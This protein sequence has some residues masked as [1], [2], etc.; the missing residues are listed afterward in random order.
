MEERWLFEAISETYVPLIR[1][2]ENLHRDGIKF[3]MAM[4]FT[5]PLMSM[6]GDDLLQK[7]YIRH[8]TR[9][10]ELL[11][12]EKEK[13]KENLALTGLIEYYY[14]RYSDDL[15]IFRD[16]YNCNII[17]AYKK[18]QELG[19]L[20]IMT[21]CATHGFL[22]HMI[23]NKE[24]VRAQ[25]NVAC[26]SY[27][28][29]LGK[30]PKGIWLAECAYVR[31]E[32]EFLKEQNLNYFI[33][34]THGVKF[35]DPPP[36]YGNFAPI[37]SPKGIFAFPRDPE[38]SQQVW[39]A[40]VGY[41]GAPDYREFYRDL[42][43]EEEFDYIKP[44]INPDGA[45][46]MTGIKYYRITG[47]TDEK[48]YYDVEKAKKQAKIHAVDF[49]NKRIKQIKNLSKVMDAKTRP[50]VVS[51]YDAELYGHWW[52]EGPWFL[53]ELFRETSKQYEFEFIL[54]LEYLSKTSEIQVSQMA[55]CTWG[56]KGYNEFWLNP[57]NHW[58]YRHFHQIEKR[59]IQLANEFKESFGVVKRALNQC[60]R[61]VLLAESS[62]WAFI[63]STN[64]T[65]QYATKRV[66]TH[67]ERFNELYKQIKENKIDEKYLTAIE[68]KDNIFPE[69]DYK[70][71]S[72]K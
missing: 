37:M 27:E 59:M 43:F 38:S 42:G 51:P 50:L 13:R 33:I 61:E 39:S 28:R 34:E 63:M 29:F 36:I 22:P 8:V 53:E 10:L 32:E 9:I 52:Y 64:T 58:V 65:V 1:M 21:C 68:F 18:F 14:E 54:P 25:L 70:V 2:F 47:K 56:H 24:A 6:L 16:K 71:Y 12:K 3:K 69:I 60:A 41:P 72:S 62:D 57:S 49:M 15:H 19:Y 66:I 46:V 23:I 44:Y 7:R 30:R 4:S 26:N 20:E 31:E 55:D 67:V 11:Q 35:A 5:P 40:E 45:R 17:N 48:D